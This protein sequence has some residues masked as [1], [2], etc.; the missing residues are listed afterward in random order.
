M[1]FI[2]QNRARPFF[3]YLAANAPHTPLEIGDE[4]VAP[5][6]GKGLDG[7]TEKIYGMVSN[8]D[9][10]TGR[11]LGQLKR[12]GI[13]RETM[14]IFMTDNGPQ[15]DR[16]NAGL[17][18][19][20]GTV[21]EGGIRVPCFIRQPGTL[22]QREVGQQEA[23]VDL[24][25]TILEACG[26]ALPKGRE[27]DGRPVL[28][29]L[30]ST[31]T[32]LDERSHFFQWHRGD[33][34]EAWRNCAVVRGDWKLVNGTELYNLR[35][36][37]AESRDLRPNE[38]SVAVSL[39]NEYEKW[40]SDVGRAGYAPPRIWGGSDNENPVLLTRQDWRGPKAAW[41][42]SGLGHYEV[43]VRRGGRYR[44]TLKFPRLVENATAVFDAGFTQMRT[45]V[46]AGLQECSWEAVLAKPGPAR[47]EGRIEAGGKTWGSHYI[48]LRRL[49]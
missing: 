36:D 27:I 42:A 37:S 22:S 15:Q 45:S 46:E 8:I 31:A 40:F 20:K 26:A 39:R 4:W 10:N 21:Y 29:Q 17:R 35:Q 18:G 3:C 47:I 12:L 13:D 23:H 24:M 25:P 19:R 6:R 38:P 43:D 34:P 33:E 16:F 2:E 1:Q 48:E 30:N 41:D 28:G 7:V 9:S 11:L 44:V 49:E 32:K 14:L 5:Y